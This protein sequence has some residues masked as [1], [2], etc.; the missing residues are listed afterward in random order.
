MCMLVPPVFS[1][2]TR[3]HTLVLR[4]TNHRSETFIHIPQLHPPNHIPSSGL[5]QSQPP[6]F[7]SIL[8]HF[9]ALAPPTH[10][11][12]F[13]PLSIHSLPHW[14]SHALQ[15]PFTYPAVCNVVHS[16]CTTN[17]SVASWTLQVLGVRMRQ[18]QAAKTCR[19]G[20]TDVALEEELQTLRNACGAKGPVGEFVT[21]PLDFF[22]I[23]RDTES[24]RERVRDR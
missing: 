23:C 14:T 10:P 19:W 9:P 2:S 12:R 22:R 21:L 6:D 15:W 7:P 11:Y 3:P 5:L 20:I 18:R 24:V 4:P 1:H 17:P 16:A 13:H 8:H